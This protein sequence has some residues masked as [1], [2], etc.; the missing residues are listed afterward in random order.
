MLAIARA[1]MASPKLL[2]LDEPSLGLAPIIVSEIAK[3]IKDINKKGISVLLVE[4]NASLALKISKYGYVL[5]TG[6]LILQGDSKE[7]LNNEE[8]KNRYLGVKR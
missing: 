4:Q 8:V 5:E 2:L 6:K 1:L 7:L 3:I